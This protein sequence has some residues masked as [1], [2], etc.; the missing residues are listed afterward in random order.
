M[1]PTFFAN[2]NN[3]QLPYESGNINAI[4]LDERSVAS[5]DRRDV[6]A[7]IDYR[8]QRWNMSAE[9][10]EELELDEDV[11]DHVRPELRKNFDNTPKNDAELD[12]EFLDLKLLE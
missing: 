2:G 12:L 11:S 8:I 6:W 5:T 3:S 1:L 4:A 10:W 7:L 9:G